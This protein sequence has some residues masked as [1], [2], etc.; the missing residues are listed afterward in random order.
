[1]CRLSLAQS[2]MILPNSGSQLILSSQTT[3]VRWAREEPASP[4]FWPLKF[5]G[6]RAEGDD[7]SRLRQ[8]T[9]RLVLL[10]NPA[11]V[12]L[13]AVLFAG[14]W[15]TSF[16]AG[17]AS[18]LPPHLFY[19][20]VIMLGL[21]YGAGGALA[22]AVLASFVAGPALPADVAAAVPQATSDWVGRGLFFAVIGVVTTSQ[23]KATLVAE[24]REL[25]AAKRETELRAAIDQDQL[26]LHYQPIIHVGSGDLV[27]AEALVRWNHPAWGLLGPDQFLGF[28]EQRGVINA[29]GDW[30]LTTAVEDMRAWK[31]ALGGGPLPIQELAVN[32]SR[33]QFNHANHL[34]TTLDRLIGEG[35]LPIRLVVEVTE[36]ALA[37]NDTTLVDQLMELRLRGVR[38]AVDDFGTG[39]S[40]VLAVRDLPVDVIKI[41]QTFVQGMDIDASNQA[42][43]ENALDLA[44]RLGLQ[45]IAEGVETTAQLHALADMGATHVQG[46]RITRPL[47]P[48]EFIVWTEQFATWKWASEGLDEPATESKT[49]QAHDHGRT[50]SHPISPH[51]TS[52]TET[53]PS[54]RGRQT[55]S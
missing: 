2:G 1:M 23:V 29:L 14:G 5:C 36:T 32:V 54:A 8:L 25:E 10:E 55:A 52:R 19:V 48:D 53:D 41:D 22:A 11:F 39:Q 38:I 34:V 9:V 6:V 24:R 12:L 37:E 3:C 44:N 33:R 20:P 40:T 30:V 35:E 46:Y 13:V 15:A 50:E 16:F 17:G 42:I 28:A 49:R 45:T 7:V 31:R 51:P 18:Q 43:I 26:E 21:R 27:G 4:A 47:P